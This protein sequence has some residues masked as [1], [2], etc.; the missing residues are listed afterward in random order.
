MDIAAFMESFGLGL[1][2]LFGDCLLFLGLQGSHGRGEAGESSDIDPVVILEK[3]GR[4]E[5]LRYR[6]FI[7]SLPEKD[8][9]CGFVASVDELRAWDGADRACLILDTRP[10]IGDLAS[11]CPAVTTDDIKR[12]VLQGACAIYHASSH[13]ILHARDWSMLPDLYKSA[14]FTIR[15]KHY[16]E[17]GAYVHAFKDLRSFVDDEEKG[18]LDAAH[19][20]SEDEAFRL[21]EWASDTLRSLS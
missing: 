11:L 20:C 9:I 21:L 18:I 5:L 12:A 13:N 15:M 4:D 2:S 3:C 1:V 14:R 16:R 7:D 10:V 19:P 8:I 6:S 17:R